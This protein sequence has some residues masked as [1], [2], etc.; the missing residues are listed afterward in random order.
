MIESSKIYYLPNTDIEVS[1]D[2]Q[3]DEEEITFLGASID[4]L[5]L[6]CENLSITYQSKLFY[7]NK[8]EKKSA[9][10]RAWFQL[11]LENDFLSITESHDIILKSD[12]DEHYPAGLL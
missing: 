10:L 3:I 5:N 8:T 6:D 12:R 4:G 11:Q 9:S 7:Q 2:Y 1:V